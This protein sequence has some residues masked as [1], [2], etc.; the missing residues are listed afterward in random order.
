MTSSS[1]SLLQYSH[2][3]LTCGGTDMPSIT[4]LDPMTQ[5]LLGQEVFQYDFTKERSLVESSR[6]RRMSQ[7]NASPNDEEL[8]KTGMAIL[9]MVD[10]HAASASPEKGHRDSLD[11]RNSADDVAAAIAASL[12]EY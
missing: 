11:R 8:A 1:S 3:V 7:D 5:H 4:S 2:V 12:K 6:S 10:H 9:N